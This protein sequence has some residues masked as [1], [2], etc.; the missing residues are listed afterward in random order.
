MRFRLNG[1][2]VEL[3][4][5]GVCSRL[6]DVEPEPVRQLGV[7]IDGRVY[8]VKQAFEAATGV[9]RRE[10]I[11]HTARRHLAALGFELVGEI[12]TEER[13]DSAVKVESASL[14]GDDSVPVSGDAWSEIEPG[15][16]FAGRYK[17]VRFLGEGE[18]KRT[19]MASD[20]NLD[21]EVALALIK[22]E[23]AQSDPAGTKR[24][25]EVLCQAGSHDNIVTLF[26]RG[27]TGGLEYL[28][29]EY[30]PGGTLRDYLAGRQGDP[31]PADEVMRFGRQ[32]A[33]ALSQVHRRGLIHRDVAPAN[34]W[35][36]ER[37]VAH[38]GDFDSAVKRD[39]QGPLDDLPPTTEAYAAPEEASGG[40]VDERS[41]LF[42]L[43]ALLY[44]AATGQR[45][46]RRAQGIIAPRALQPNIPPGL[47][48]I[49]WKLLSETPD[50]RPPNASK[51][52]EAL[53]PSRQTQT[54]LKDFL[55]W[56][57]TLPFPLASIIWLYH[58]EIDP[59]SKVDHLLKFFEA[60]SQLVATIHLSAFSSDRALF[61]SNRSSWFGVNPGNARPADFG[62]GTFGLWVN[63][64]ERL[65]KT[66]RSMLSAG[67]TGTEQC[68]K[69]YAAQDPVL[70]KCLAS[71]QIAGVMEGAC[72]IRNAWGHGGVASAQE[73]MNRLRELEGLLA[74]TQACVASSFETCDLLKPHAA[75]Y[76]DGTFNYTVTLLT[77][78]NPAFRKMQVQVCHPLDSGRLY[79]LCGGTWRGLELVPLLRVIA[80]Q[81]SGDEAC[82]FYSR[83]MPDNGVK[84]V[85]YHFQAVPECVTPDEGV[86]QFLSTLRPE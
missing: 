17:I 36:D 57:E 32:L 83:L 65:A 59:R 33:R 56:A 20:V 30:L 25:V 38:L 44:E 42:S 79:F 77:G 19:F 3:T 27:S 1:N 46:V 31:L 7:R 18:R 82:Y 61:D 39:A 55:P 37:S 53:M 34:V 49:I 76:A 67:N 47:N 23:A 45:P 4:A 43:G 5:D 64:C 50:D 2:T 69:L 58:A 63:L 8:P 85:S 75:T 60:L 81:D 54:N 70:I 12:R 73:H 15:A 24:E 29:F 84:W 52:L 28:V 41:D 26:D 80:S 51:V 11:S 48:A 72:A 21:R 14:P 68:C 9:N 86:R 22:P 62:H 13:S 6:R 16:V 71:R 10:F 40:P 35:L 66:T 78:T 74:T